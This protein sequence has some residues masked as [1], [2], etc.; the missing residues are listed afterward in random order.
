MNHARG[1][2]GN[3]LDDFVGRCGFDQLWTQGRDGTRLRIV[4]AGAGNRKRA[5]CL[6]G[7]PQNA[8]AWRKLGALLA[9]SFEVLMP[10]LRGFGRSDQAVSGAYDLDTLADDVE[11]VALAT[12]LGREPQLTLVAHDWGGPIAWRFLEQQP[13][14][15]SHFV[16]V[17]GPHGKIYAKE[18][19][20]NPEQRRGAWYTAL[21]QLPMIEH[22]LAAGGA[23]ALANVLLK[24]SKAG[25]FSEED[26][27]LYIEPLSNPERLRAAL[28]YYRAGARA[29]LH[30]ASTAVVPLRTPTTLLWGEQDQALRVSICERIVREV[31]PHATVRLL[32]N[33]THWIPDESP[34]EIAALVRARG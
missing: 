2:T 8:A 4:R 13:A 7:F 23:Q 3:P 18:L 20:D 21:F 28:N 29:L 27:V 15:V 31:V 34:E 9:D 14:R 30:S 16:C 32:P 19:R 11:R 22:L 12:D 1:T 6:H 5:L 10:D 24:T 17:N 33:G 26:V 25:T